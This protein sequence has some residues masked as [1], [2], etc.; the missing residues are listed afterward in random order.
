MFLCQ[1]W[2]I[3]LPKDKEFWLSFEGNAIVT[4]HSS[5][6]DI[7]YKRQSLVGE[8]KPVILPDV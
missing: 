5:R 4:Q 2:G 3:I 7:Q 1:L 8:E 6:Q